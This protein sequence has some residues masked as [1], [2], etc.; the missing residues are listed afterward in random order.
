[1]SDE[2]VDDLL[3]E[4]PQTRRARP[5]AAAA[6]ERHIQEKQ[7]APDAK[8]P[9]MEEFIRPVG[10]TFLADVFRLDTR[11]V[12]KKLANCPVQKHERGNIPLYDFVQAAGYLVKPKMSAWDWLKTLRV[13]DLPPHLAPGIAQ[14]KLSNQTLE[15]RAG[16]LWRSEDVMDV[17]GD[18]FQTIKSSMQLWSETMRENAGLTDDQWIKFRQLVDDLQDQIHKKLV[19]M[20]RRRQTPNSAAYL[21]DGSDR[22]DDPWATEGDEPEE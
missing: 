15:V 13:Q 17:L 7:G 21:N 18:V 6:L 4:V 10:V 20:P 2:S 3:G 1:M 5:D 14:A 8:L 11:T 12:K 16:R 19:D 9:R 22:S